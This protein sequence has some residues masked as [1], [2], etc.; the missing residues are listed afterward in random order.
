MDIITNY[1][2]DA[3]DMIVAFKENG[4]YKAPN[5]V[6]KMDARLESYYNNYRMVFFFKRDI[7]SKFDNCKN[8]FVNSPSIKH[9]DNGNKTIVYPANFIA[10]YIKIPSLIE[11]LLIMDEELVA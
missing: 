9:E 10:G 2:K 11:V 4:T 6:I 5:Q 7:Y 8:P 1:E 3:K